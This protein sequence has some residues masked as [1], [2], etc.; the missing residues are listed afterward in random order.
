MNLESNDELG[1]NDHTDVERLL[2]GMSLKHPSDSL[3]QRIGSL[4]RKQHPQ[5]RP[6]TSHSAW[7]L[8]AAVAAS[9]LVCAFIGFKAGQA[10]P[11]RNESVALET[12]SNTSADDDQSI[13]MVNSSDPQQPD[14]P[15]IDIATT[16][17][18][19]L[20][21]GELRMGDEQEIQLID[22]GLFLL[23]GRIPVR[24]YTAIKERQVQI[25]DPKTGKPRL[26]NVPYQTSF[27]TP[28]QGT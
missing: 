5:H 18:N 27:V 15:G 28:A 20:R 11:D 24:K 21:M 26:M 25:T 14:S 12:A 23:D 2:E 13:P 16:T 9:C 3:D 10:F 22:E 8:P 19:E 1:P 7:M 6:G 4:T 17:Q